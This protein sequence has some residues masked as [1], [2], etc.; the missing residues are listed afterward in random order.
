M[1]FDQYQE[2]AQFMRRGNLGGFAAAIG[3][4]YLLADPGNKDRLR[5]SFATLFLRAYNLTRLSQEA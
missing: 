5:R 2:A 3:D 1:S 4:A